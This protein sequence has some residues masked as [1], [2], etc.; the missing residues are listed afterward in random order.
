MIISQVYCC[1]KSSCVT[2]KKIISVQFY[3]KNSVNSFSDKKPEMANQ[4]FVTLEVVKEL[5]ATQQQA[6]RLLVTDMKDRVKEVKRD[7]EELKR[8][9]EF[10]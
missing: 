2:F 3:F 10:S 1:T 7:G 4:N 6:L 5:L 8:S 9:L